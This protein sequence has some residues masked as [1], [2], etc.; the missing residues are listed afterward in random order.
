MPRRTNRNEM[1]GMLSIAAQQKNTPQLSKSFIALLR[2]VII[3]LKKLF[4]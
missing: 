2:G 4:Y 3:Y 1:V